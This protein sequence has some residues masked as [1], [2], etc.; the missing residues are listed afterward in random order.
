MDV[1]NAP[2]MNLKQLAATAAALIT[3]RDAH[4]AIKLLRPIATDPTFREPRIH[5]VYANALTKIHRGHE[6]AAHLKPLVA[7][8]GLLARDPFAHNTLAKALDNAGRSDEAAEHLKPLVATGGLLA[9]DPFA[10]NTLAK[11]LDNAGRSDEAAEHLKPLVA[12]GG[13]RSP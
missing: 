4:Q 3:Q 13:A 6:A 12:T 10:H 8:G 11:A 1:F 2:I 9:R 7:S 5:N